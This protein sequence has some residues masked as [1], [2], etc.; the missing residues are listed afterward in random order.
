M[1]EEPFANARKLAITPLFRNPK[2]TTERILR[3]ETRPSNATLPPYPSSA[4]GHT[5]LREGT[6]PPGDLAERPRPRAGQHVGRQG[7]FF[8]ES[9]SE[10]VIDGGTFAVREVLIESG[11]GRK[12]VHDA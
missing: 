2:E 3:Q 9:A 12:R 6:W 5:H 7:E 1:R 8:R 10:T 4:P 11:Y